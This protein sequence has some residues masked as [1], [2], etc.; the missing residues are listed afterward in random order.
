MITTRGNNDDGDAMMIITVTLH[1]MY[2]FVMFFLISYCSSFAQLLRLEWMFK[3]IKCIRKVNCSHLY[4]HCKFFWGVFV[5]TM[6]Y[7]CIYIYTFCNRLSVKLN[8][9]GSSVWIFTAFQIKLLKPCQDM[10]TLSSLQYALYCVFIYDEKCG[11][12]SKYFMKIIC[13]MLVRH[14]VK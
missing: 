8:E 13:K 12:R 9:K 2:F 10:Y 14:I 3:Y 6:S 11:K 5:L 7:R 1:L 4:L